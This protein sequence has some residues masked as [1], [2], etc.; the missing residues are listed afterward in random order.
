MC[1]REKDE[2]EYQA[3]SG[4]SHYNFDFEP[5]DD[6]TDDGRQLNDDTH[7]ERPVE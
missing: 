1:C 6:F 5:R 4:M 3:R 2:K 7:V